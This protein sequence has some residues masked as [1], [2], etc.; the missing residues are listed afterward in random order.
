MKGAYNKDVREFAGKLFV[1]GINDAGS[2]EAIKTLDIP[3][4]ASTSLISNNKTKAA[5]GIDN[6]RFLVV[7]ISK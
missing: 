5:I 6:G 7:N 2:L 4:R 1:L 3:Y